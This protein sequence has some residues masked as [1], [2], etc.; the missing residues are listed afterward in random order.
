MSSST[1]GVAEFRELLDDRMIATAFQPMV[2]L[3][4]GPVAGYEAVGRG[5]HPKL[6]ESPAELF[7]IAQSVGAQSELSRLFRRQAVESVRELT[8]LPVIFLKTHPV[9]FEAPGLLDC[10]VELR[11]LAPQLSLALEVHESALIS[12]SNMVALRALLSENNIALA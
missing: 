11:E 3:P 12:L 2:T 8:D 10:L 9:E 5:H 6:P 1:P 4:R 7:R